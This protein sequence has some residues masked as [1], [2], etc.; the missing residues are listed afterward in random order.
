MQTT[1]TTRWVTVTLVVPWYKPDGLEWDTRE[2]WAHVQAVLVELMGGFTRT[3]GP[4]TW[5]DPDGIPV[6][7]PVFVFTATCAEAAWNK[8]VLKRLEDLRAYVKQ[9]W[10]QEEVYMTVMVSDG[11]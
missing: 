2:H 3:H 4:G 11:W 9:A 6:E 7:E 10:E 8:D 1:P 5:M